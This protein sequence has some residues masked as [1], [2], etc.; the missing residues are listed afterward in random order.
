MRAVVLLFLASGVGQAQGQAGCTDF[1]KINQYCPA[2]GPRSTVPTSCSDISCATVFGQWYSLCSR[3]RDRAVVALLDSE[4]NLRADLLSFNQQCTAAHPEC[5]T[6]PNPLLEISFIVPGNGV[7]DRAGRNHRVDY[8]HSGLSDLGPDGLHFDGND[9]YVNILPFG[10]AAD[11][12]FT[13]S[14]WFTKQN[15]DSNHAEYMFSD[16]ESIAASDMTATSFIDISLVCSADSRHDSVVRYFLRDTSGHEVFMDWPLR[17]AG[18][19]DGVTARW[20]EI[21]VAVTPQRV[22][23]Y[24][25]GVAVSASAYSTTLPAGS[26]VTEINSA[27][28][29]RGN[30]GAPDSL[31]PPLQAAPG[32]RNVFD[33]TTGIHVGSRADNDY[34]HYFLGHIALL[35]VYGVDIHAGQAHCIFGHGDTILPAASHT[36]IV[37]GSI[38]VYASSAGTGY[39]VPGKTTYRLRFPLAN[40]PEAMS[41]VYSIFGEHTN[42]PYVPPAYF[43]P[44]SSSKTQPPNAAFYSNP[45]CN[46]P[47]ISAAILAQMAAM[48]IDCDSFHAA[49]LTSFLSLGPDTYCQGGTC[50]TSGIPV[51]PAI[52]TGQV[53]SEHI[54]TWSDS[55][56]LTLGIDP[57]P[58]IDF[59]LFW[60]NPSG[61]APYET[62]NG[63]FVGG[64]LIAQLTLPDDQPFFV[65]LGLQGQ[66][67]N[68]RTDPDVSLER[69]IWMHAPGGRCPAGME[70]PG[71]LDDIDECAS[72][73]C[74]DVP[75]THYCW[76]GVDE[77]A[78]IPPPPPPPSRG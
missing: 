30:G 44:L 17:A 65:R 61:P 55:Q 7:Q 19:S 75:N 59:A 35:T 13:V 68:H 40:S 20:V 60:M 38:E 50:A 23:T 71:C 78:C 15:C 6:V 49:A 5:A 41:N 43:S 32:T 66:A 57:G 72:N 33:L 58:T 52:N 24:E 12:T 9:D 1:S 37:N 74:A 45:M 16:H 46:M 70:G 31:R 4:P 26:P 25:D 36:P 11:G 34:R 77:Y 42:V 14:F 63:P 3:S 2:A 10:Y 69:V 48:G 18:S 53:G 56:P 73:P 21:L 28:T 29:Q 39:N 67:L 64:P 54:A 62:A 8:H 27:S 51:S 76:H 22:T 47:G